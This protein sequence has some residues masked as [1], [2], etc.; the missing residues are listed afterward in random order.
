[1]DIFNAFDNAFGGHD[2][3]IDQSSYHTKENL[4]NGQD[5]YQNGQLIASTK[6]NIFGGVDMYNVQNELLVSTKSNMQG[7]FHIHSMNGYE[8]AISQD[9]N[10]TTHHSQAGLVATTFDHGN[11]TTI[12]NYNDPLAHIG[13]YVLP[14]LI[15]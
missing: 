12:L 7:G 2:F 9:S 8:G 6:Q 13:S 4:F 1:L 3:S 14:T 15:L 5:V 11:A 10:G